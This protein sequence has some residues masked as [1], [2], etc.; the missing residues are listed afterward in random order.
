MTW[1]LALHLGSDIGQDV[2]DPLFEAW[3][4]A[5]VG[6]ALVHQPLHLFQS[7]VFW[8]LSDSL[9][10]SDALVGY[11]PAG[12]LAQRDAHAALIVYNLLFLGAYAVA[13]VGAYLLARELGAGRLGGIVAGVAFA[14]APW[15]LGQ[16]GHLQVIS[17]GGIPLALFFLVRGYRHR[18]GRLVCCGWFVAAWQ[19]TLGFTLGL[20]L[21]YLLA[22]LVPICAANWWRGARSPLDRGLG[23]ATAIGIAVF[24]LLSV[25]Q[26]LPYLRVIHAH[27]EAQRTPAQVASFSPPL[28]GFLAAPHE[29]FAWADPTASVRDPSG[30]GPEQTLF[31]GVTVSLLAFVGLCGSVYS[32]RLR[33]GVATGVVVGAVL[34]LGIR[35]VSGPS[36]Y[37]TPYRFLYDFAPGWDAVRT[38]GRIN[39]LT[40]L[41]LALFAAAGLC[42]AHDHV[43]RLVL[44]GRPPRR[45]LGA[46][47]AAV[48]VGAILLEGL[49]PLPHPSVPPIPRGQKRAVAPQLHL[50]LD[51][52]KGSRYSYW[53]IVGFPTIVNGSGAFE[54]ATLTQL[55]TTLENFPDA[56]SVTALRELGV[57]TVVLH[58]RLTNGTPWQDTANQP[59]SGLALTRDVAADVILYYLATSSAKT[60]SP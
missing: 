36:K 3:Q 32:R 22:A 17:S 7:N 14:Y 48:F 46:A 20:Q 60:P 34:S 25:M 1:P 41:G 55:H 30:L 23:Y 18:S 45:V 51:F 27:P 8:P 2:G 42:V 35:D 11:A 19:M 13:F 47:L 15:R 10:F 4:V 9:A 33:I 38:P 54:P 12:L 31:P 44:S 6:H 49:G 52:D 59:I 57:R 40:S 16:N 5:W 43:Q 53:S 58:P 21:A 56:A 37:L 29:S 50:P 24:V 39:T 26:A 28:K